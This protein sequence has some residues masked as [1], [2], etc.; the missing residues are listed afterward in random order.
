M[1]E[2][3]EYEKEWVFYWSVVFAVGILLHWCR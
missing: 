2:P 1:R 3:Y